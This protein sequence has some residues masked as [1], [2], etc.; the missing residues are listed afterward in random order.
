MKIRESGM[1]EEDYWNSFFDAELL[2]ETLVASR[3]ERGNVVEFGSGYGTFTVPLA[4]KIS[5]IV[6][7]F[8]IETDLVS[9]LD[10]KCKR[11][12]LANVQLETRDFVEKGTGLLDG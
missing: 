10:K 7:G 6:Y 12:C 11:L 5:G 8:D 1:P 4:K 3:L 2:I 9:L